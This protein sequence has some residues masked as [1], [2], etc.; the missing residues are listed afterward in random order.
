MINVE[1]MSFHFSLFQNLKSMLLMTII[2][3]SAHAGKYS[4]L[5]E[6]KTTTIATN[7]L[8]AKTARYQLYNDG[9]GGFNWFTQE[10]LVFKKTVDTKIRDAFQIERTS[11]KI[12]ARLAEFEEFLNHFPPD[13]KEKLNRQFALSLKRDTARMA[14]ETFITRE[15]LVFNL[16]DAVILDEFATLLDETITSIEGYLNHDFCDLK[17]WI[18]DIR[19]KISHQERKGIAF[20]DPMSVIGLQTIHNLKAKGKNVVIAVIEKSFYNIDELKSTAKFNG[21]VEPVQ[22]MK[23]LLPFQSKD[24]GNNVLETLMKY[25]P[26]STLVP[27][28]AR[29]SNAV[30]AALKYIKERHDIQYVNMSFGPGK[31]GGKLLEQDG[32]L[33]IIPSQLDEDYLNA[34]RE[35]AKSGKILVMA[36]GNSNQTISPDSNA[37]SE[38]TIATDKALKD[39]LA[40]PQVSNQVVIVQSYDRDGSRLSSFSNKPG[41]KEIADVTVGA[42]GGDIYFQGSMTFA[43]GTSFSAPACTGVLA[44]L[45]SGFPNK[46][47][48]LVRKVLFLGAKR[49]D[50]PAEEVGRGLI[51]A[52][53]AWRILEESNN[54]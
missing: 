48:R 12:H 7:Y 39:L 8:A 38:Q 54:S 19:R 29:D 46:A 21:T 28:E 43:S 34:V 31:T 45:Q 32:E 24:H 15:R 16:D 37:T 11:K 25:A 18:S 27:I 6:D 33:T 23:C 1:S 51:N 36:A 5:V 3:T 26:E 9:A 20:S 42:P 14:K 50:L 40:D 44:S 4:Q 49:R 30:I 10:L 17:R 47:T 53:Q 35:C 41:T 2:A 13:L 22:K 52:P